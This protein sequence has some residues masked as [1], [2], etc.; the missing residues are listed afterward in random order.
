MGS[1]LKF[2]AGFDWITPAFAI[3]RGTLGSHVYF[4]IPVDRLADA[5]I[6]LRRSGISVHDRMSRGGRA[7]F[8]VPAAKAAQAEGLL[9]N[10]LIF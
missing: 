5:M 3:A 7:H 6:A 10:L 4:V 8:G 2:G 1:I 9:R